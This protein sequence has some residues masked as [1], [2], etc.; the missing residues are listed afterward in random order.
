MSANSKLIRRKALTVTIL[1][2]AYTLAKVRAVEVDVSSQ[3][4]LQVE[5]LI[6]ALAH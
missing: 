4:R 6:D 3:T 5:I 1:A 2:V